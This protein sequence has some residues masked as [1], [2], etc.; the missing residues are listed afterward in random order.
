MSA[1]SLP[2]HLSDL[3]PGTAS[4]AASRDWCRAMSS[5][6]E[7]FA[8]ASFLFPRDLRPAL[9]GIYAFSRFSDDLADEA[10]PAG[11]DT[12]AHRRERLQTWRRMVTELPA[13]AHRHPILHVLAEDMPRFGYPADELLHLID[14]FLRDQDD[15]PYASM[16]ELMDYCRG[17]A[18]PVGRLLLALHGFEPSGKDEEL[19]LLGDQLCAGLQLA[20]FWQDLSRDLPVGRCYLP[21]DLLEKHGLPTDPAE[22]QMAGREFRPLLNQLLEIAEALL[23]KGE[24]LA[25]QVPF[26]FA[27][28]LRLFA[29]GGQ[30]I[31]KK[32]RLL[33]ESVLWSRPQVA[34]AEKRQ[35]A[36]SALWKSL[37]E[38]NRSRMAPT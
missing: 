11:E 37:K 23:A 33:G 24:L 31:V 20:N 35:L 22:I 6:Y 5:H 14:A 27:L 29:G 2:A 19:T 7:N 3:A 16:D 4:L 30:L 17:S 25:R 10:P 38:H 32:T 9:H 8:L 26:R 15:K 28:D 13:G 21:L 18:A 12:R 34:A 1:E 36:V